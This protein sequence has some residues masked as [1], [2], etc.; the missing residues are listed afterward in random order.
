MAHVFI[1]HDVADYDEWRSHYDAHG[2]VRAEAGISDVAV[3]RDDR[4][5]NT[6]WLVHEADPS[7]VEPFLSDPDVAQAMQAAGVVGEPQVWVA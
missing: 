2:P 5:P 4:S 3:L 1:R 7:S 6:V